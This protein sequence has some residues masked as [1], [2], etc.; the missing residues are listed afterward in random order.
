MFVYYDFKDQKRKRGK[1][2][3]TYIYFRFEQITAT[4]IMPVIIL[5]FVLLFASIVSS[6]IIFLFLY[7]RFH[8]K[9]VENQ[10]IKYSLPPK[11][12]IITRRLSSSRS[13]SLANPLIIHKC[14]N[15]R[16]SSIVDSKLISQIQ[17]S[18]PENI[19]RIRRRSV[20]IC[21]NLNEPKQN[22][23]HSLIQ[24]QKISNEYQPILV[25]FSFD[26]LKSSTIQIRFHSITGLPIN[27]QQLTIKI[28]LLP[29]GKTK[30]LEIKR[31]YPNINPFMDENIEDCVQFSNVLQTKFSDK[32]LIMK[33]TG[34][35]QTKKLAQLGQ[36]GKIYFNQLR[37][38]PMEFIHEIEL[39]KSVRCF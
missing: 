5:V 23:I 6:V 31:I 33:I 7:S 25:S 29:D 37:D 15:R 12:D 17:F 28:R 13:S 16:Q 32:A 2:A 11:I 1:H 18:L 36:I 39:I 8:I 14:S 20:A 38:F 21:N 30:N 9:P 4:I 3:Y 19:E 34:K 22:S 24:T 27:L 10:R 35:D 26:Y